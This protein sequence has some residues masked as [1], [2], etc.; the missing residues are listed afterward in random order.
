MAQK[1]SSTWLKNSLTFT[2]AK[3][4]EHINI[5]NDQIKVKTKAVLEEVNKEN[6][7]TEEGGEIIKR[8]NENFNHIQEAFRDIDM[9]IQGEMEKIDNTSLLFSNI[10]ME[11]ESIASISEEQTAATEELNSVIEE[12]NSN[13]ENIFL[14][15]KGIKK[16]SDRLLGLINS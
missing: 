7:A 10:V 6:I 11:A 9:H 8:V 13:V 5:I 14:L 12:N 16:S 2:S 1:F 15:M 3:T 4:V